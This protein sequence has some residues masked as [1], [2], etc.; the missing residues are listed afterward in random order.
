MKGAITRCENIDRAMILSGLRLFLDH[1]RFHGE[2]NFRERER[3]GRE[4]GGESSINLYCDMHNSLR[5]KEGGRVNEIKGR[6]IIN[7]EC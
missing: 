5:R 4:G 2:V 3:G 7:V 6:C 1:F